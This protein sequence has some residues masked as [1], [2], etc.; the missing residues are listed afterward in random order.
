[1]SLNGPHITRACLREMKQTP[2]TRK[3]RAEALERA[4]DICDALYPWPAL[5]QSFRRDAWDLRLVD[6][7]P[8]PKQPRVDTRMAKGCT[9]AAQGHPSRNLE[10]QPSVPRDYRTGN[11]AGIIAE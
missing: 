7:D 4:A 8:R 6:Y 2:T 11:K 3:A 9:R 1:M 10:A 5:A